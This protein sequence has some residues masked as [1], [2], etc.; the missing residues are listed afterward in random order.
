MENT[1]IN[2]K[3]TKLIAHA[4]G[5]L[6]QQVVYVG[7]AIVSHYINDP[8]AE[9]VRPTKDIDLTF[10][11][12]SITELEALREL[13][14]DKG[15]Y[16][17]SEDDVICRFRYKEETG[18]E[19][20]VDVMATETVGWAPGNKWLKGGYEAAIPVDIDGMKIHI[21]PLPYFLASKVYAFRERGIE[22]PLDSHDFEDIVYVLNYTTDIQE[23]L[24]ASDDE[25]RSYL[26]GAFKQIKESDELQEAVLGNL[27]TDNQT[28]RYDRIM[29][30]LANF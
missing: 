4:L 20:K 11:I 21:M 23:Q 9:D 18:D 28:V 8:A 12:A 5:E 16:Q 30:I 22:K 1:L 24:E 27:Y 26:Q 6:N 2:R 17:T 14:T 7:G 19:I 13:L 29:E 10:E 15:F 25:T 3:A